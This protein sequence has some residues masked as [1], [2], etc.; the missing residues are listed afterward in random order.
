MLT[1]DKNMFWILYEA[2]V[3][4]L[5]TLLRFETCSWIIDHADAIEEER[6]RS[7]ECKNIKTKFNVK[8]KILVDFLP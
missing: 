6:R 7:I 8:M 5:Q 4:D 1:K 3:N 2:S